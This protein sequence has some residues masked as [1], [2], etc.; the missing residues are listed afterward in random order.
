MTSGQFLPH[1]SKRLPAGL[2]PRPTLAVNRG[3]L[4]MVRANGAPSLVGSS[5]VVGETPAQLMISD[6][7]LRLVPDHSRVRT[8]YLAIV[9]GSAHVR[10]QI[11]GRFNGSSGQNNITQ[12]EIREISVPVIPTDIQAGIVE[13]V[14]G[15]DRHI[16]A[17][18]RLAG[19][20]RTLES[21]VASRSFDTI[22]CSRAA[23]GDIADISSGVTLGSEAVGNS[24]IELPYLRVANVLDGRIDTSDLKTVKV[25]R[26]QLR[27]FQL[28][29]GDVLLTEGGDIDKLGRGAV[30]NGSVD[31][32]LHQNHI[33]R[34]RCSLSII[35]PEFLSL[36][37]SSA[38]GRAYF[39]R[40]GKQSTNL[41]SINVTQ[42]KEMKIPV[43]P[44]EDQERVLAP[45]LALR[46][47]GAGL[48]ARLAKLRTIRSALI[49]DLLA[50]RV[51][52]S[53]V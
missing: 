26:S 9:L 14:D 47:K 36:Y 5:C 34:V 15:F 18:E 38:E 10:R 4:L 20:V 19:K 49:E 3:D 39:H 50:G 6:K 31:P 17:V 25:F 21:A 53:E 33:F 27:R 44:L 40:V 37:T 30:W 7:I 52:P 22:P 32:C 41:A 24:A 28:K 2:S 35:I 42:V 11:G 43:P 12:S 51:A 23:M 29:K 13:V 46:R 8:R 48:Q 45:I 16:A 1:E